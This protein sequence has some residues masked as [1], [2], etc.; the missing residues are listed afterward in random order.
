[1]G[2]CQG[3]NCQRQVMA[4]VAHHAGK[5]VDQVPMFTPRPPVKPV[6]IGL[7]AEE[8]PEEAPVA[9]VG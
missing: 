9:E 5:R 8:K 4:L 7:V 6:P 2:N 1:M 3:R